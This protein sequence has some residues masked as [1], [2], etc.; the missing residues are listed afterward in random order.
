[1]YS[2][3]LLYGTGSL[4]HAMRLLGLLGTWMLILVKFHVLPPSGDDMA[5]PVA[6]CA[7]L[8]ECLKLWSVSLNTNETSCQP[9]C[10]DD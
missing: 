4:K 3:F 10:H 9:I 6:P 5:P 2:E 1:M 8:P 7:Q